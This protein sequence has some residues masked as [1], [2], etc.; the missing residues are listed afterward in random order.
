[1]KDLKIILSTI[2]VMFFIVLSNSYAQEKNDLSANNMFTIEVKSINEESEF[3]K[4]NIKYPFLK[5]KENYNDKNTIKV[6]NKINEDIEKYV[7]NFKEEIEKQSKKYENEYTNDLSKD[8]NQQYVKYQY[9]AYSEYD[10]T[11]NKN[12]IISIPLTTYNF[13]GG[14]H[15]ITYLKSFNYNLLTGDKIL[16]SDMFKKDVDYKKVINDYINSEINKNKELYFTGKEGFNGISDNQDFYIEDDGIVIY[17]QVYDIAP[18]YVGIPKF[19]IDNNQFKKYL[20][21]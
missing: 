8:K 7:L 16:L 11:Y 15:G 12:N 10:V 17:F 18:Y 5:I 20:N 4:A 21:I 9:E 14:A 19:K 1:M 2:L 13:T 6:I 3:F